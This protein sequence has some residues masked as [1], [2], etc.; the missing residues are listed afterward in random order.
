MNEDLGRTRLRDAIKELSTKSLVE[1]QIETAYTWAFRAAAAYHLGK[2]IDGL[3]Y[4]H[5]AIEHAALSGE[6][7]VLRNVR[8][9]V[10]ERKP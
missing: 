9:I 8:I 3:E 6:D 5:E 4:E 1:I 2:V 7:E 10:E